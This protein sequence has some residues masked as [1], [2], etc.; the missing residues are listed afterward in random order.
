[1]IVTLRHQGYT[2]REI[3]TI[4]GVPKSTCQNIIKHTSSAISNTILPP[5]S[6]ILIPVP[7][8]PTPSLL[9]TLQT[10]PL[11]GLFKHMST[12]PRTG[13]PKLLTDSQKDHLKEI[14]KSNWKTRRMG[15]AELREESGLGHA[16]IS[17]IKNA[18][19]EKGLRSYREQWK[20]ILN[21]ENRKCRVQWC[22]DKQ[23]WSEQEWADIA[24]TDEM[25]IEV[26][27]TYGVNL[28][29][30]EKGEKWHTDC[31]GQ[32]KKKCATVMC[33]GMIGYGWKGPFYVWDI[34]TE[35]EKKKAMQEIN[36]L[37]TLMLQDVERY[38]LLTYYI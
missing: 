7:L 31:I 24:F 30:R 38:I 37:N 23:D 9:A 33:W 35:E 16:S 13:R 15:V 36:E 6:S 26:G 19:H 29:W 2:I 34:E 8:T 1:M 25:S 18:L 3:A 27:G 20:F 5:V 12:A 28:I 21:A 32:K 17:T 14:V 11:L 4:V 22:E 10:V